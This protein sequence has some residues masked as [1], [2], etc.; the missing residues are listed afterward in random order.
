MMLVAVFLGWSLGG[1]SPASPSSQVSI[2]GQ[3]LATG[4]S[5]SGA[6]SCLGED[7]ARQANAAKES[8]ER[9]RHLE[10]AAEHYRRAANLASDDS[11]KVPALTALADL[12]DAKHL[13]Q[14]ER[15]EQ[16]LREVVEL[17]PNEL[18]HVFRLARV[19]EDRALIDVAENTLLAARYRQPDAIEPYMMLA[20]FYS[21][22]ALARRQ[23]AESQK[24]PSMA[25]PPGARDENGVF[26]IGGA[27]AA[28]S[29]LGVA[30]YPPEALAAGVQGVVIVEV[31]IN[32]S[33]NVADAKVVRSIPLLDEAALQAVRQWQ[34]APTVVNGQ[35][36]PVKMTVTVNF[37]LPSTRPSP[38]PTRP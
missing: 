24:A 16:V 25:T 3:A 26:A 29:R 8:A 19:Q 27:L 35:A 4:L 21:R 12:H 20:Q 33:G 10:L 34:Y 2:C 13:N 11:V 18:L 17:Q 5:A 7:E 36:S 31:V 23:E 15:M 9:S 30:R 6:E 22:R 37:T 28:P 38:Q 32:E 14:L 1:Q